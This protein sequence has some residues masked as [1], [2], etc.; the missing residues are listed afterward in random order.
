M[1]KSGA[2]VSSRH[3]E[4]R[5]PQR[6]GCALEASGKKKKRGSFICRLI[7]KRFG[8]QSAPTTSSRGSESL[9][10]RRIIPTPLQFMFIFISL[11][12][13]ENRTNGKDVTMILRQSCREQNLEAGRAS[14][15]PHVVEK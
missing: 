12:R 7:S 2:P 9:R 6:A 13:R 5:D 1:S 15:R 3:A 14:A 4:S 10:P 11:V 8:L